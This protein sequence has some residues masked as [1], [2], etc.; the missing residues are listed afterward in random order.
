M[1]QTA[2]KS[3]LF[4]KDHHLQKRS[5]Y[6]GQLGLKKSGV[7]I[8]Y[9]KEMIEE[10]Q[11]CKNDIVYFCKNYVKI[12]HVDRGLISFDMWPFQEEM[13]QNIHDNRF[14][15]SL[16]SRQI[17]KSITTISYL[18][19]FI[20]FHNYKE[21]GI[22][23]NKGK[24]ARKILAKLKLA[25]SK[26]PPWLQSGI[27]EWN[28]GNIEL[29]NGCKVSASSTSGDAARGDS[30]AALFID[31]AAFIDDNLWEEFYTSVYPTVSSGE[32]TK[33]IMVSTAH[34]MNHYHKLWSDAKNGVSSYSPFEVNWK[35]VPGR[36]ET[37][38][39]REI[40][41]TSENKFA[42]EHE[43]QF[44]GSSNTLIGSASLANMAIQPPIKT[45]DENYKVYEEVKKDHKYFVTVDC[46]QGVGLDYSVVNVFD[47]T[48]YPFK[49]VAVYRD[50]MVSPLYFPN[51]ILEI[52]TKYNTAWTLVEN[53]DVGSQ[54]VSDLNYD[55]EYENIMSVRTSNDN[56]RM[57]LGMKTTKKTKALGCSTFKE[58][59]EDNKLL[60]V[61]ND[62]ILELSSFVK[63]MNSYEAELGKHDDITM[64]MVNFSYVTTMP[65]FDDIH[66]IAVQAELLKSRHR[67]VEE[68]VLPAPVISDGINTS[69][70]IGIDYVSNSINYDPRDPDMA[71]F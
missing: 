24:T 31:E 40:G 23:A 43:N 64:T 26:M 11:K 41:N 29:E 51:V 27:V 28:K 8:R 39:L 16:C 60:L 1:S 59:I 35:A 19:H 49:Q 21:L 18:L 61:D 67:E 52:A 53:N 10:Y 45:V 46:G 34:G 63:K 62:T 22:I 69:S 65:L 54:I 14:S 71:G 5:C 33:I 42:Q 9:T 68:N 70:E 58:L 36:D 44:L 17:G 47:I 32:T 55:L 57:R 13:I 2:T 12:V 20:L 7:R 56:A 50:N 38:R 3:K 15:I 4:I 48:T 30:L 37:W 66:N 25:Y 6:L